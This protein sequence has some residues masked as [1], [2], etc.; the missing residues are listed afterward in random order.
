M[1]V[2]IDVEKP[3]R[4]YDC[5]FL[6][7][8]FEFCHLDKDSMHADSVQDL[9]GDTERAEKG[10]CPIK[11]NGYLAEAAQ[12]VHDFIEK[13][14]GYTDCITTPDGEKLHSDW[15]YVEEGLEEIIRWAKRKES[16]CR[17]E[18]QDVQTE[19]KMQMDDLHEEQEERLGVAPIL[20]P[21]R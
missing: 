13:C 16:Q 5:Q 19:E 17:Y 14:E 1:K 18:S 4:C 15:G 8:E 7:S 3:K 6:D 21:K 9:L 11:Q 20:N 10:N 2:I 12:M